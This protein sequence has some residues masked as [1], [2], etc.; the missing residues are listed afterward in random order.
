MTKILILGSHGMLGSDISNEFKSYNPILLDKEDLDLLDFE[1]V[2]ETIKDISPELIINCS[3]YT[4]VDRAEDNEELANNLNAYAVENL[5]KI[6]KK[7]NCIFLQFSTEYIFDGENKN[8]YDENSVPNSKN[9]YGRSKALGEKLLQKNLKKY[10]IIRTS[11]LY[12][13][14]PQLGKERGINFVDKIIELASTRDELNMVND[15]FSKP[16]YTK[17]LAIAIKT[18]IEE[19]YA[20]GIYHLVNE[21]SAT[22]YEF[23]KE[24]FKIKSI[25]IKLSPISYSAYPSKVNRPINALLINTKFPHLRSWEEAVADYLK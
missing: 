23:A 24:I 12:G 16:T 25:D 10:Y 3:G 11:W 2:N 14:N 22:P 9:A 18:I 17:D 7:I 8:A 19:K 4:D 1:K 5:A 15:Q 20:Y 6:C 13:K 21:D